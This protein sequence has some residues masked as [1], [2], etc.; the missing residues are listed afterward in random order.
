M[1][2]QD[3]EKNFL[4]PF[5]TNIYN[6]IPT[7]KAHTND[8]T[9]WLIGSVQLAV[10]HLICDVIM[11]GI[12]VQWNLFYI[13]SSDALVCVMYCSSTPKQGNVMCKVCCV[14]TFFI[15]IQISS[16]Y[17]NELPYLFISQNGLFHSIEMG[18]L[19]QNPRAKKRGSI[20]NIHIMSSLSE[21]MFIV[22]HCDFFCGKNDD[23]H[24]SKQIG[25]FS[26]KN[27]QV[28]IY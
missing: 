11:M 22:S 3:R 25:N 7:N 28:T 27:C 1:N 6:K 17:E 4:F 14:W 8:H 24:K 10:S 19:H 13:E 23:V 5:V 16:S 15:L 9:L 18:H 20:A 26:L 2:W 21:S 12:F